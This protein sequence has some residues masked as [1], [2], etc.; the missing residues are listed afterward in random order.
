MD[1]H[2]ARILLSPEFSFLTGPHLLKEMLLSYKDACL[3]PLFAAYG[4]G[5]Q[6]RPV[7]FPDPRS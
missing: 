6:L 3:P 2:H 1:S 5:G 7:N 4:I